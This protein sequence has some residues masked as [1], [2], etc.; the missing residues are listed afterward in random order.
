MAKI[1][2][3]TAAQAMMEA[4]LANLQYNS[5]SSLR[6][7]SRPW[8]KDVKGQSARLRHYMQN[9]NSNWDH[10]RGVMSKHLLSESTLNFS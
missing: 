9:A 2:P 7:G 3:E 6:G 4:E 5:T 10:D 8:D 1:T